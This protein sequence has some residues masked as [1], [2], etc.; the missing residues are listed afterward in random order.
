MVLKGLSGTALAVSVPLPAQRFY[1]R[2][3]L[4]RDA[5]LGW[6][7]RVERELGGRDAGDEPARAGSRN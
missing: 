7:Q 3:P 5:L 6:G 1:G 4:L 2:E